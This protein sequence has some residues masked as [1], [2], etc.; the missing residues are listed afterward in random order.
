VRY[1]DL[2]YLSLSDDSLD[3]KDTPHSRLVEWDGGEWNEGG[4]TTWPTASMT[5]CRV[6]IEQ[7]VAISPLGHVR[8]LG[9][10][11]SHVEQI[12]SG[13]ESPQRRGPLR[14][15]RAVAGVAYAVGMKR[16]V[17]RR[18]GDRRWVC[19]DQQMRPPKG[20]IVGLESIDGFSAEELYAAGW[21][22]EI[23]HYDGDRWRQVDSPTNVVVTDLCAGGETMYACGQIG[24][25]LRGRRDAW[26]V[27]RHDAVEENIWSLAWFQGKL[28]VATFGAV[29]V[30]EN[31]SLVPVTFGPDSPATFY[32]LSSADGVLWSIGRKDVMAFDGNAWTRID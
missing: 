21:D 24:T 13:E 4:T 18:E 6:P 31:D 25:L 1:A 14:R 30:L 10:G 32:H 16:Q 27:V 15:V 5:V 29:Y 12:G 22:G 9:S 28:Y 7:M 19:I 8:L 20:R 26:E 2:A 23:W 3:P 17:Y 11:D